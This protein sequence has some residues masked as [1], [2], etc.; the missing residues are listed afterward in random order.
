M[1]KS[2]MSNGRRFHIK[3]TCI[4]WKYTN[5]Q[6]IEVTKLSIFMGSIQSPKC[7]ILNKIQ[8]DG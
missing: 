4:V 7:L 1:D 8:D 3:I 2:C 5:R 6:F